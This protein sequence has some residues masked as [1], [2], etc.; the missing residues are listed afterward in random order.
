VKGLLYGDGGQLLAQ[1]AHVLIGFAWAFGV[2]WVIFTVAKRF[3][4]I[5]VSEEAEIEGL[6]VPEFGA[7]CYPDFV[8]ATGHSGRH[9]TLP[10]PAPVPEPEDERPASPDEPAP[11]ATTD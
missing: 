6:D 11:A 10:A 9:A 2:T 5:R 4:K 3:M 8:L 7:L 1:M